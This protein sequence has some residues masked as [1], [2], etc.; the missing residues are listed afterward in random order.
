MQEDAQRAT[1][2]ALLKLPP[3]MRAS[4]AR[5]EGRQLI[6]RDL[7]LSRFRHG[8][9]AWLPGILLSLKAIDST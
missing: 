1:Y 5:A 6:R 7:R 8:E 4:L 3:E 9:A 2:D